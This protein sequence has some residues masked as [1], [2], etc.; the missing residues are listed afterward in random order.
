V[1]LAKLADDRLEPWCRRLR[2][3]PAHQLLS[4]PQSVLEALAGQQTGH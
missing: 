2:H 3:I 4:I 1:Q